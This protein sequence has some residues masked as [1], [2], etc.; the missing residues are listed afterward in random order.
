VT[1]IETPHHVAVM[2]H[3]GRLRAAM[4]ADNL[5]SHW[6][7]ARAIVDP[8]EHRGKGIGS[9]MLKRLL[10]AVARQGCTE[11]H[12]TPGGYEGLTKRQFNFYLKNGFA[13]VEGNEHLLIWRP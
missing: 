10:A 1:L 12:V 9:D 7:L 11:L 13:H 5:G 4:S 8:A 3:E 6:W 2:N